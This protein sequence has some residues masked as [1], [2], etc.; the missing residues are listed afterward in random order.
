MDNC[1]SKKEKLRSINEVKMYVVNNNLENDMAS[2]VLFKMLDNYY[3]NDTEYVDK[4]LSLG[5]KNGKY[6][7]Y[8]VNLHNIRS[9]KNNVILR[10]S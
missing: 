5:F 8:I 1:K 10:F 3:D 2:K 6:A 9:K 4:E 7:K